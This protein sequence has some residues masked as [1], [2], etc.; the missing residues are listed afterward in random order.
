MNS[1]N[2]TEN[3]VYTLLG[4][5]QKA[6]KLVSGDDSVFAALNKKSLRLIVV[7]SDLSD[8]SQKK[9]R[10]KLYAAEESDKKRDTKIR[11]CTFGTKIS[12]G[13]AIG[14][15]PRGLVAVMDEN[16]AK[17]IAKYLEELA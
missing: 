3:K 11:V 2:L 10:Q 8:N 5:A 6:G 14:K 12:L 16:F 13:H 4:F 15:S 1:S 17:A 7:A 9:F